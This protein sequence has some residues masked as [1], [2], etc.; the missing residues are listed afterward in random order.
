M[1]QILPTLPQ[2][3]KE[4]KR[5]VLMI[6]FHDYQSL[7]PEP[8]SPEMSKIRS[9]VITVLESK[10]IRYKDA[11][12]PLIIGTLAVLYCGSLYIDLEV[13]ESCPTY[14][15]ICDYLEGAASKFKTLG[16]T[17]ICL[18]LSHADSFV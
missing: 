5:D 16:V 1:P 12:P 10:N 8:I 4:K 15:F 18:P 17:L 6:T 3:A 14:A 2:I 13:N 7:C 11:Y 9:E